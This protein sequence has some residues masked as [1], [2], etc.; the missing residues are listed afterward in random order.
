[1]YFTIN[2][3]KAKNYANKQSIV[4]NPPLVSLTKSQRNLLTEGKEGHR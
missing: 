1:M 2:T 4:F 3:A